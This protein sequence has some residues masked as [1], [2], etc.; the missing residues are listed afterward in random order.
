[1]ITWLVRQDMNVLLIMVEKKRNHISGIGIKKE[2]LKETLNFKPGL[3]GKS[4]FLSVF[5]FCFHDHYGGGVDSHL[6]DMVEG[7]L[8]H[9]HQLLCGN[10]ARH[11]IFS[12]AS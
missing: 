8:Q 7:N 11:G 10:S 9:D 4:R 1:M 3:Y 12:C 2:P 6:A 5:V